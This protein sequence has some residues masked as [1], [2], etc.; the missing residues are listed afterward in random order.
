MVSFWSRSPVNFAFI[1]RD[2]EN[3]LEASRSLVAE[4]EALK[5]ILEDSE[6]EK[7]KKK[8]RESLEN[9]L[10][11]VKTLNSNVQSTSESVTSTIKYL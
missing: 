9:L 4:I 7:V 11:V 3:Q 8:L 10:N 1:K 5:K 6:D 2:V